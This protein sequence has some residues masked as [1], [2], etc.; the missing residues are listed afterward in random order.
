MERDDL[1]SRVGVRG[2]ERD[3]GEAERTFMAQ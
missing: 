3:S 2:R 1:C